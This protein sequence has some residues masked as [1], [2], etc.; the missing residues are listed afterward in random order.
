M[1]DL[2]KHQII[3]ISREIDPVYPIYQCAHLDRLLLLLSRDRPKS[4]AEKAMSCEIHPFISPASISFSVA[5]P[6]RG[7]TKI[8]RPLLSHSTGVSRESA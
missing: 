4:C 5:W 8:L 6:F 3:Q 2:R 7:G 1:P